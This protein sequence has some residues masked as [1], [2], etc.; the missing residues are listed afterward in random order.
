MSFDREA[1]VAGKERRRRA[2]VAAGWP[3]NIGL[4]DRATTS[5]RHYVLDG[6]PV[7]SFWTKG[8]PFFAYDPALSLVTKGAT[9]DEAA[10][11]MAQARETLSHGH[12]GMGDRVP[13]AFEQV[14][15]R[16]EW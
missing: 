2:M 4:G 16:P 10:I 13:A 5:A 8:A 7:L 1:A 3:E 14:Q 9:T 12:S 15:E 6:K 11:A